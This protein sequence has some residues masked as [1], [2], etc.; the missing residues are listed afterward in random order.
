MCKRTS[1]KYKEEILNYKCRFINILLGAILNCK[2]TTFVAIVKRRTTSWTLQPIVQFVTFKSIDILVWRH[3][4]V[5]FSM[6]QPH[7]LET[8]MSDALSSIHKCVLTSGRRESA[9]FSEGSEPAATAQRLTQ[10]ILLAFVAVLEERALNQASD[11]VSTSLRMDV[12]DY[13]P[14]GRYTSLHKAQI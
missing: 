11:Q 2:P 6:F 1:L 8:Y 5:T 10:Q 12:Q 13:M 7:L 3:L 4:Y 14:L 9:L